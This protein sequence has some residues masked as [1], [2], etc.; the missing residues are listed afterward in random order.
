MRRHDLS[1][2]RDKPV[3]GFGV[4]CA[5]GGFVAA[6]LI[7]GSP[8][9][10]PPAWGDIPTWFLAGLAAVGGWTALSQLRSQQSQLRSQQEQFDAEARRNDKRDELLDRQLAEAETRAMT[11]RRQQAEGARVTRRGHLGIV[12]NMSS[13]PVMKIT[14]KIMSKVDRHGLMLPNGSGEVAAIA[15]MPGWRFLPGG[16]K[17]TATLEILRPEAHGGFTF[18]DEPGTPDQVLVAW[19]TDDAGFRWQLDEFQH[20][21]PA[22]DESEYLL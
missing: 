7:F 5:I 3:V 12:D 6:M 16:S 2:L 11:Q 1:W 19:F 20:L 10:L 18:P 21:V 4:G 13:R 8:W 14:C 9:H 17:P 22:G 15:T